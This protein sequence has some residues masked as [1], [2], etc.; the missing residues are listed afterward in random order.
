MLYHANK[1][2]LKPLRSVALSVDS[3]KSEGT[4]DIIQ[5]VGWL[6]SIVFFAFSKSSKYDAL[7]CVPLL[8]P[9]INCANSAENEI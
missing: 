4:L 5:V 6:T 3:G 8:C 7:S 1:L 9:A 2:R